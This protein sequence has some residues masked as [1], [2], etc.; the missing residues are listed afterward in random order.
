[1]AIFPGDKDGLNRGASGY[2]SAGKE[3]SER[4]RLENSFSPKDPEPYGAEKTG[5]ADTAQESRTNTQ[6]VCDKCAKKGE[7]ANYQSDQFGFEGADPCASCAKEAKTSGVPDIHRSRT[8]AGAGEWDW[9][10]AESHVHPIS[11]KK[12]A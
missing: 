3:A 7:T 4:K 9:G 10:C 1:M 12:C 11:Q 6:G 8:N 2:G 5:P